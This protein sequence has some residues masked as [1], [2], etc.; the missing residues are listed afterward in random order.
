MKL[1]SLSSGK[2]RCIFSPAVNQTYQCAK[3]IDLIHW[4]TCAGD[5]YAIGSA[6]QAI[7]GARVP[8]VILNSTHRHERAQQHAV[9][10]VQ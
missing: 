1:I 8:T 3:C 10:T 9:G 5:A 4:T 6:L 2:F 7:A